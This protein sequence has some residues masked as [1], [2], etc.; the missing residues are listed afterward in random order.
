MPPEQN[1]IT[2]YRQPIFASGAGANI[3]TSQ[4]LQHPGP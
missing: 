4:L 2:M 3:V 1:G